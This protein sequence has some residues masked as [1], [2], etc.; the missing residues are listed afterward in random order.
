[1]KAQKMSLLDKKNQ[2][3][4][5]WQV[6]LSLTKS[7]RIFNAQKMSLLDKNLLF[8]QLKT[9]SMP[10]QH[11]SRGITILIKIQIVLFLQ[12]ENNM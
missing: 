8:W 5:F 6:D 9:L 10:H 7:K 4:L 1:M 2:N 12:K 3:L 11:L